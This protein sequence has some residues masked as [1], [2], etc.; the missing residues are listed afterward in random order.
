MTN[1]TR[2]DLSGNRLETIS[3]SISKLLN[4]PELDLSRNNLKTLSESISKLLNLTELY[5]SH[6]ELETLPPS[7]SKLINLT[8]L[9]LS[10]NNLETLPLSISKLT[11]LTRLDLSDNNLE[12][13]MPSVILWG[14]EYCARYVKGELRGLQKYLLKFEAFSSAKILKQAI[15]ETI[16]CFFISVYL[17][18][19]HKEMLIGAIFIAPILLFRTDLSTRL[20]LE[21]FF[22]YSKEHNPK[23]NHLSN[24][25]VFTRAV[26]LF[27]V[28]IYIKIKITLY[29]FSKRFQSTILAIP[30]NYKNHLAKTVLQTTPELLPELE[31]SSRRYRGVLLSFYDLGSDFSSVYHK[32]KIR[33]FFLGFVMLFFFILSAFYRYTI[34]ISVLFYAP[35][36]FMIGTIPKSRD[37]LSEDKLIFV[38]R[39]PL[40]VFIITIIAISLYSFSITGE[41]IEVLNKYDIVAPILKVVDL[42]LLKSFINTLALPTALFGSLA[43]V[44][45]AFLGYFKS[46][47]IN[48]QEDRGIKKKRVHTTMTAYTWLASII[49]LYTIWS[50]YNL[51]LADVGSIF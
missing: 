36:L 51:V 18:I 48:S 44:V 10:Y 12:T 16:L 43:L 29:I 50:V 2:L 20:A 4:L 3:D 40:W 33:H 25:E 31:R 46:R 14:E 5:L 21:E 26:S 32:S 22:R 38:E 6:N 42:K 15:V 45:F 30:T 27:F 19:Y 35:F 34:K 39:K 37:N 9:D 28:A 17:F 13:P 1:L 41:Y 49:G 24:R 47:A 23:E 11:K 7:I 8:T